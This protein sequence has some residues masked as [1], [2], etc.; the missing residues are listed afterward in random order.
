MKGK[1][2]V[3]MRKKQ[4]SREIMLLVALIVL[5]AVISG[6]RIY[7]PSGSSDSIAA[8]VNGKSI[9]N[10]QVDKLHLRLTKLY[11]NVSRED[12]L[13]QA[14]DEALLLE[15]ADKMGISVT[16]A[17]IDRIIF[18]YRNATGISDKDLSLYWESQGVSPEDA[19]ETLRTQ[20]R[21]NILL[22][23]TIFSSIE[24]SYEEIEL[25]REAFKQSIGKVGDSEITF[26]P[27]DE[28]VR[29]AIYLERVKNSLTLYLNQLRNSAEI[30]IR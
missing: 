27:S 5:V 8:A 22:N 16:D 1:K 7:K 9:T 3:V 26:Q 24:I 20:Q 6:I 12:A 2:L 29:K 4:Y 25:Y 28:E 10:E 11:A 23:E 21:I 13:Q 15:E 17:D 30:E 19:H 18:D 14:I